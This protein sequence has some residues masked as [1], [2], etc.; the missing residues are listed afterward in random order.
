MSTFSAASRVTRLRI[1]DGIWQQL[2][3]TIP[4]LR[5]ESEVVQTLLNHTSVLGFERSRFWNV[6][7]SPLRTAPL[8]QLRVTTHDL[9]VPIGTMICEND[10]EFPLTKCAEHRAPGDLHIARHSWTRGLGL[11]NRWWVAIPLRTADEV[12]GVWALD[13]QSGN[14]IHAE[15]LELLELITRLATLAIATTRYSQL[16]APTPSFLIEPPLSGSPP[17]DLHERILRALLD[18]IPASYAALFIADPISRRVDKLLE[19]QRT[20]AGTVVHDSKQRDSQYPF[21]HRLTGRAAIDETFHAVPD[22]AALSDEKPD[23]VDPDSVAMHTQPDGTTVVSVLYQKLSVPGQFSMLVRLINRVDDP[24]LSFTAFHGKLLSHSAHSL[25]TLLALQATTQQVTAL[26]EASTA[27]LSAARDRD[28]YLALAQ[29]LR[30]CRIPSII[31][32]TWATDGTLQ[33]CWASDPVLMSALHS[34]FS[35]AQITYDL[36]SDSTSIVLA[37]DLPP[38]LGTA[39]QAQGLSA[40]YAVITEDTDYQRHAQERVVVLVPILVRN[41]DS[42]PTPVSGDAEWEFWRTGSTIRDCI[43]VTGRLLGTVRRI[44]RKSNLLYLAEQ[45][46]ARSATNCLPRSERSRPLY[47]R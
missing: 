26:G 47:S 18:T 27:A 25:T 12:I 43:L 34:N 44:A 23:L 33:E 42:T 6:L 32:L 38:E 9:G 2:V 19:L 17:S 14:A 10:L 45:S 46:V 13:R 28:A 39:L 36:P 30:A 7:L 11:E 29:S 20:P 16:T 24:R 4:T 21:G 22:F 40:F 1:P 5:T 3:A 41:T 31:L 15:E 35:H 37:S 8:F